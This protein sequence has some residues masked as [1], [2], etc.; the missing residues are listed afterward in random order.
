MAAWRYGISLL[1]L[2][3]ISLKEKFLYLQG[4]IKYPLCTS[5]SAII[6]IIIIII[7]YYY[8]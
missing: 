5:F 4:A 1:L 7:M 6:I 8:Y 3:N 2:K